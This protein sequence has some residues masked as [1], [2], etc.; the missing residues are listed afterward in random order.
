[1]TQPS[2][3]KL[4]SDEPPMW[5]KLAVCAAV[6]GVMTAVRLG[7]FGHRVMPIAFGMPLVA[8][9][10]LRDRRLLWATVTVF[11]LVTI[12]KYTFMV[13]VSDER[14]HPLSPGERLLDVSLVLL[15]LFVI[16][17]VLH[18]L[19]GA[20]NAVRQRNRDLVASNPELTAREEEI[21]R[22]NEELQ[23]TTEELERQ[24]EELR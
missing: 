15:D 3:T 8:F 14:G 18:M 23:S 5:V 20:S 6:I 24:S 7:F 4:I 19:I 11:A 22:Q 1:M 12:Y 2:K 10:W 17:A 21:Q 13:P 9:A 16:A